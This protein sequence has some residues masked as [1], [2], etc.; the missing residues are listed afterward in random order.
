MC[1]EKSSI[2]G[3][4]FRLKEEHDF[5]WLSRYGIVFSVFDEQDSGNICFGVEDRQ[6]SLTWEQ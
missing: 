1:I 6:M 2:D 5:S 4:E 3:I